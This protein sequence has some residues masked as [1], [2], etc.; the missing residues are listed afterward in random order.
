MQTIGI[1]LAAGF[2]RR[3]GQ[4]NKLLQPLAD[5]ASMGLTAARHLISALPDSLAVVRPGE[6]GFAAEL[7][8]LGLQVV[9]CGE[10]DLTM[11]DSLKLG[12]RSAQTP[13]PAWTGVVIALADMPFIQPAT[14]QQVSAH[15][16]QASIV[17]PVFQGQPGHPVGFARQWLGEL[18][19]IEGDQGARQVLRRHADERLRF[20]CEDAGILRDLDTPQDLGYAAGSGLNQA[21]VT[22][23]ADN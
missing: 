17:Q 4:H 10:Q 13:F 5:G 8:A 20:S 1:L 21:M 9:M 14:I 7:S 19:S 12:L 6:T 23:C 16:V 18:L 11:S 22:P 2:S 3:F 15:L